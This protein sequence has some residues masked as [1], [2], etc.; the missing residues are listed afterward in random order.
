MMKYQENHERPTVYKSKIEPLIE[1]SK[2]ICLEFPV[3]ID[4]RTI[5]K[6]ENKFNISINIYSFDH[7][8]SY[9]R[10]IIHTS[11][12]IKEKHINLLYYS[13][14]DEN[15][16]HYAW[17]KNF[18]R[19]M[20]DVTKHNEKTYYCMK[21]LSHFYSEESLKKH[22]ID[23]PKCSVNNKVAKLTL[24][25]KEEAFIE[26][27]NFK[28]KF[29]CPFV[30]YCDFEAIIQNS[31]TEDTTHNHLPCGFAFYTI[32]RIPEYD[33]FE[34]VL[35]RGECTVKTFLTE[36]LKQKDAIMDIL[37]QHK[38]MI[39]TIDD[40]IKFNKASIC[41]I[42]EKPLNGDKVRDHCHI[43]GQYIGAA[44][45]DCNIHRNTKYYKIPVFFHNGKGYDS[46]FII[47]EISNIEDINNNLVLYKK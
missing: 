15:N 17:I 33:D 19:F 47:N 18:N 4:D 46:H 21:C 8:E 7:N 38:I 41:H 24:P 27:K 39:F 22:N 32:S 3:K 30:I 20:C 14:K 40:R 10:Y 11:D 23:Y 25:K 37:H 35:Y 45:N 31:N 2:E 29:P 9:D 6:F 1:F 5:K 28:N 16:Y 26:F 12:N 13:D 34:P 42:C 44:H 43:T 36:L